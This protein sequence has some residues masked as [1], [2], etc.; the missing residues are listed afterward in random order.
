MKPIV[1]LKYPTSWWSRTPKPIRYEGARQETCTLFVLG[2]NN[3]VYKQG[4]YLKLMIPYKPV[5]VLIS[6]LTKSHEP[7]S[8]LT[9]P[10]EYP[11][12]TLACRTL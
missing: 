3:W 1:N 9:V 8:T 4:Y 11:Y 5:E 10:V 7:P 12:R 2:L 6:E